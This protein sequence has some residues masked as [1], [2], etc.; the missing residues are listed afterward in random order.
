MSYN[1][2][3]NL[4][5]KGEVTPLNP[6]NYIRAD[7]S[8]TS[9]IEEGGSVTLKFY[10][11]GMYF[12]MLRSKSTGLMVTNATIASWSC[13]SPFT[14]A[15]L[16]IS[17][18]TADVII[19]IYANVKVAPQLISKPFLIQM[20]APLDTRQVLTKKEMLEINDNY[21]P[22]VYFALCRDNGKFYIYR[23]DNTYVSEETGK[24]IL[25]DDTVYSIDGGEIL[26]LE[27]EE[28]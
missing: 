1:I 7:I 19:T 3:I 26:Q 17:N 20:A 12:T 18:P 2:K 4:I 27:D 11:D 13:V 15:T 25:V 24:F 23:K 5:T 21:M 16:T 10:A 6:A 14:E 8:N 9:T 22:D 28:V